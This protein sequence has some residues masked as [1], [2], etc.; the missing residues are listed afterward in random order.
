MAGRLGVDNLK[1]NWREWEIY[2]LST[3]C[4]TKVLR[5]CSV[6]IDS[7]GSLRCFFLC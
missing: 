4:C 1:V 7:S 3:E 2:I 6:E 5:E